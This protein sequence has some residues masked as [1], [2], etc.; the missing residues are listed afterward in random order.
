MVTSVEAVT[1]LV[2]T[3]KLA[4]IAPAATVTEAGTV[5]TAGLLLESETTA[6]PAGASKP[7]ITVPLETSPPA[8]PFGLRTAYAR[9]GATVSAADFTR[10][11]KLAEI[12]TALRSVTGLVA[13]VKLAL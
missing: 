9:A 3:M 2:D 6:P 1:A 4:V 11:S 13:I 7:R 5:A 8:R 12:V 10:S